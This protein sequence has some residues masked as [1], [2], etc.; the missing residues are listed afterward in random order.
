MEKHEKKRN[1][2][3]DHN[4]QVKD[5][6]SSKLL[7]KKVENFDIPFDFTG[8]ILIIFMQMS[9]SN[10]C[11]I[12]VYN[13]CMQ[14]KNSWKGSNLR[15]LEVKPTLYLWATGVVVLTNTC[16]RKTIWLKRWKCGRDTKYLR[17]ADF[18][19]TSERTFW[20]LESWRN[21]LSLE[22]VNFVHLG[23]DL[24][25]H[26]CQEFGVSVT[27]TFSNSAHDTVDMLWSRISVNRMW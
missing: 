19:L 8:W 9:S 24:M 16:L 6:L 13:F 2:L 20:R 15:P 5:I 18:A 23:R 3:K 22:A 10:K 4:C 7:C 17:G 11:L 21:S 12:W 1:L 26:F 27:N 14:S 25:N